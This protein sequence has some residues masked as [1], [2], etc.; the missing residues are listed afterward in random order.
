MKKSDLKSR[1]A[2][3]TGVEHH[4]VGVIVDAVFDE[5]KKGF[6][7]GEKV[8][9]RGFGTFT[10]RTTGAKIGRIIATGAPIDIPARNTIKFKVSKEI[11][12][13]INR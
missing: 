11:L 1:V 12:N 7:T 4:I 13:E 3:A 10:K 9:F 6:I 8:E 2:Q 5:L